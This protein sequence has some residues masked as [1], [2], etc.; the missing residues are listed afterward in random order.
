MFAN[1][2]KKIF[3]SASDRYVKR[4]VPTLQPVN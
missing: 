1:L 2:G 3:G 4:L